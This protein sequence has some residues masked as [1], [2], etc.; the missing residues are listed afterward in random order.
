M[1]K[2][3]NLA[4]N[5]AQ[6]LRNPN[7]WMLIDSTPNLNYSDS[8]KL[9]SA[10][11]NYRIEQ[12]HNSGC[13]SISNRKGD[14]FH[15]IVPPDIPIIDSVSVNNA[16]SKIT[17]GWDAVASGDAAG[18][19][20]YQL[21]GS[22]WL[23]VDT[24]FGK[25]N[26]SFTDPLSDPSA[27]TNSYRIAAFDSC[28]NLSPLGIL[29]TSI[30]L[31]NSL[32][33]CGATASL[34][35]TEYL[36]M[37]PTLGGYYIYVSINAGPPQLI[38]TNP[39][40]LKSFQM[41]S[42]VDGSTYCFVIS[43]YNSTNTITASSNAIC[44]L[45]QR[46]QKPT[47]AYLRYATVVSSSY[48]QLA[49][50]I[51]NTVT[52]NAIRFYRSEAISGTYAL[53]GTLYPPFSPN[54]NL[55]D[56][57]AAINERPY[58]YKLTTVDSCG[59][60]VLT[61]NIVNTIFLT[62]NANNYVNNLFWNYTNG[63]LPTTFNYEIHRSFEGL[64]TGTPNYLIPH[65]ANTS[66]NFPD[67]VSAS[68]QTSGK[69]DYYIIANEAAPNPYGFSDITISN[70]I[71]L[72][73]QPI[74][75]IPNAFTPNQKNPI[76]KPIGYFMDNPEY[77]FIIMSR[78]GEKI[79]ES[80]QYSQGWD[81]TWHRKMAPQGVYVYYVKFRNPDNSYFEQRGAVTLIQ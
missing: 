65:I 42:L 59:D 25:N 79:F 26:T 50:F 55:N 30:L 61:S 13:T 57:T 78:W 34:S 68:S 72:L 43:A 52:L 11:I 35:W 63:W 37:A 66:Y 6:L 67:D 47:F 45:Y 46:P 81:G 7:P 27:A 23:P 44:F 54:I 71:S 22:I 15:D 3:R 49:A 18:Y 5:E 80:H 48:I 60:E 76:F 38:A 53:I 40:T 10:V 4:A 74:V 29:H 9:C 8:F 1:V 20:I 64:F 17:I 19:V 16:I 36:N 32:N 39:S 62:G 33:I 31:S 24:L 56:Y 73:Q 28:N 12:S 41:N 70:Q 58:F 77:T 2:L 75:Y 51:D 69:F 14:L 21:Q